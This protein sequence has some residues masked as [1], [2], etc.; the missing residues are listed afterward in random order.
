MSRWLIANLALLAVAAGASAWLSGPG[1]GL[2]L[3]EVPVHWGLDGRPDRIV[4]RDDAIGY[5]WAAP[6]VMLLCVALAVVLPWV[7]PKQFAVERFRPT[8]DYLWFVVVVMMAWIHAC[9]LTA[10]CV[11]G[12]DLVRWLTTGIFASFALM[13]NV[14]GRTRPNFWMGIRTPW[15]LASETVW[16][17]THRLGAWLF[18]GAGVL[19][20]TLALVGV[21]PLIGLVLVMAAGFVPVVYSLVLYK[22]LERR[23]A[24]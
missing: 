17:R 16:L 6:V 22:L 24:L 18:V 13:G 1:R 20:A 5:L 8:W 7:S 2:L 9:V 3:E 23:G 4:A 15:T 19:G 14:L 11:A 10:S 21:N 12:L